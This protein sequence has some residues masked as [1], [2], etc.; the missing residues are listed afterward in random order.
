MSK[1]DNPQQPQVIDAENAVISAI[2]NN[3]DAIN[4]AILLL[5]DSDFVQPSAA[6]VFRVATHLHE[7][8]DVIELQ[9]LV[10]HSGSN[11]DAIFEYLSEV[12]RLGILYGSSQYATRVRDFS[13]ERKLVQ[14]SSKFARRLGSSSDPDEVRETAA[15]MISKLE[16]AM[17]GREASSHASLRDCAIDSIKSI[18][19]ALTSHTGLGKP[20]GLSAIDEVTGGLFDGE[21]TTIAAR[22]GVGKTSLGI[23]VA[24]S[25]AKLGEKSIVFSLEMTCRELAQRCLCSDAEVSS[26]KVRSGY[27]S[28]GDLDRMKIAAESY[29]D[30]PLFIDDDSSQ[31]ITKIVAKSRLIASG[32]RLGCIVVDYVGLVKPTSLM[33]GR[34]R[35]EQVSEV[36][37]GLKALSKE[38]KCPVIALAQV[39]R[40][41]AKEGWLKLHHLKESGSIEEDSNAVW[42]I[43][44]TAS[45][46]SVKVEI[47]V[48]KN[49]NGQIGVEEIIWESE[50]TRFRDSTASD[51]SN[52]ASEFVEWV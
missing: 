29:S 33:R 21:L 28:A 8:G 35:S 3:P 25:I 2:L 52:Y 39:N 38:L 17:C 47:D 50:Y 43:Q 44:S 6:T 16:D 13:T 1:L 11:R 37:K 32:G 46:E 22:P 42:F 51:L 18:E 36:M 14:L 24:R 40:E 30:V 34:H 48:A 7:S 49:R 15:W 20:T 45:G 4:E 41:A 5:K 31:D 12:M 27:T 10:Q 26:Q 9:S 19:A 23:Q